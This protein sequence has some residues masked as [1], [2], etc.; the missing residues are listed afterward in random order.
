MYIE[1][2]I[3]SAI[4][5]ISCTFYMFLIIR[6]ACIGVY[7]ASNFFWVHVGAYLK[8]W[9][10]AELTSALKFKTCAS[11]S[12]AKLGL[13]ICFQA[14]LSQP[15]SSFFTRATS[16]HSGLYP[17]FTCNTCQSPVCG[18]YCAC[19]LLIT[20]TSIFLKSCI[21]T[22]LYMLFALNIYLRLCA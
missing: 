16:V 14:E 5:A 4:L 2:H 17:Y 15:S 1:M 12:Q 13:W 6:L 9:L 19:T 8:T 7:Q 20:S 18:H 11:P 21:L 3:C 22:L 10:K